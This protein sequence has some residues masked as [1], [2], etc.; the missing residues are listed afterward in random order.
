MASNIVTVPLAC[1]ILPIV[2]YD[3]SSHFSSYDSAVL[4]TGTLTRSTLLQDC[5]RYRLQQWC[6]STCNHP[7]CICKVEFQHLCYFNTFNTCVNIHLSSITAD[8]AYSVTGADNV[9]RYQYTSPHVESRSASQVRN[10]V[11]LTNAG[12]IAQSY[13]EPRVDRWLTGPAKTLNQ[14]LNRAKDWYSVSHSIRLCL[15]LPQRTRMKFQV[16]QLLRPCTTQ[17]Q[18]P[19]AKLNVCYVTI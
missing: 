1:S 2:M 8:N 4:K 18:E 14:P 3:Y 13:L 12:K 17:H 16:V 7:L 11:D 9:K 10:K 19:I 5:P 6:K 15:Q